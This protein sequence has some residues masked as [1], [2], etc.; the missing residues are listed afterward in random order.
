MAQNNPY[1]KESHFG[2]A[3]S[4]TLHNIRREK[5]M[6]I[7]AHRIAGCNRVNLAFV[8]DGYR[9]FTVYSNLFLPGNLG[10][11]VPQS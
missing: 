1:A 5:K 11:R 3:Y 8:M 9:C 7:L 10:F 4:A 2:V 6:G